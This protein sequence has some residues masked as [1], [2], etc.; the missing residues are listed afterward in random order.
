MF[1]SLSKDDMGVIAQIILS[2]VFICI[3]EYAYK[4]D[5]NWY[6]KKIDRIIIFINKASMA[7]AVINFAKSRL[8]SKIPESPSGDIGVIC[9]IVTIFLFVWLFYYLKSTLY[10]LIMAL[11]YKYLN[12]SDFRI[13]INNIKSEKRKK[14]IKDLIEVSEEEKDTTDTTAT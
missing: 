10:I 2:V 8:P 7:G 5:Q 1:E 3:F 11:H 14:K 12:K 9:F 13:F 4:Q 6:W